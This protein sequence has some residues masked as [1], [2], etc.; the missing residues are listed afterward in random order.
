[1]HFTP[2]LG[3]SRS[4]KRTTTTYAHKACSNT[5][6]KNP[7]MFVAISGKRIFQAAH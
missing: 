6:Q 2:I 7:T 1:M 5:S 3:F 4:E